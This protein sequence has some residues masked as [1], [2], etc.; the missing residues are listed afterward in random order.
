MLF[1]I[2][3]NDR[4]SVPDKVEEEIQS[5]FSFLFRH[6]GFSYT[7]HNLGNLVD[8]NG[9]LIFYG[10]LN[11]YCIYNSDVCINILHLVQRDD[12]W[13]RITQECKSDQTYI[14]NG[15]PVSDIFAYHLDQF[16][17]EIRKSI[18]SANEIYGY[19]LAEK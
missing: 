9:K 13:I 1:S 10:P 15:T 12:Y 6:Y 8:A 16:A 3:R 11:A 4:K 14:R 5:I 7:K 18:E 19:P 2:K 17:L